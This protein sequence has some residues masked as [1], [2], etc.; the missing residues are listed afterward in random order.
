[1]KEKNQ[2][3]KVGKFEF[4]VRSMGK[5]HLVVTPLNNL[6]TLFTI[7]WIFC[8]ADMHEL[9]TTF[10]TV[11]NQVRENIYNQGEKSMVKWWRHLTML[12]YQHEVTSSK[13]TH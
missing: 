8:F 12:W 10:I 2:D 1:M 3:S 9:V 13:Q 11:W 6:Y 5:M 4:K 7:G